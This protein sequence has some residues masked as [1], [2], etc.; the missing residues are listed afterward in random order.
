MGVS[1]L[2]LL[3]SLTAAEAVTVPSSHS[4]H[5]IRQVSDSLLVILRSNDTTTLNGTTATTGVAIL[6]HGAIVKGYLTFD[7]LLAASKISGL[8]FIKM[9]NKPLL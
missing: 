7:F 3:A 9:W 4:L 8:E 1:R 5:S 6:N 2:A